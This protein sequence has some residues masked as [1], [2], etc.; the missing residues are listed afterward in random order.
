MT[1]T[2]EAGDKATCPACGPW[3]LS[4][5][6][7]KLVNKELRQQGQSDTSAQGHE[8][9]PRP[10]WLPVRICL[11]G[12]ASPASGS[13]CSLQPQAWEAETQ[14]GAPDCRTGAPAVATTPAPP[15]RSCP[16]GWL[17]RDTC[18]S[19]SSRTR[20]ICTS[21]GLQQ[22]HP[23]SPKARGALPVA[24][25]A[26]STNPGRTPTEGHWPPLQPQRA[27]APGCS[28]VPGNREPALAQAIQLQPYR[29]QHGV[30]SSPAKWSP[31]R[32]SFG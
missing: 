16:Q 18:K 21:S 3:P 10:T 14:L 26:D 5:P 22:G 19:R 17:A 30:N 13:T 15:P 25:A 27:C 2:A 31:S 29:L 24:L 20:D 4:P 9:A 6:L 11:Q 23:G 28:C 32:V 1:P 8:G 12:R 7:S